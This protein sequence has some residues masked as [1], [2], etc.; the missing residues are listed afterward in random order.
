M[1]HANAEFKE[2]TMMDSCEM[3]MSFQGAGLVRERSGSRGCS[4]TLGEPMW[5]KERNA[6]YGTPYPGY[7]KVV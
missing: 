4:G 2:L 7:A 1:D 3:A 5:G 6:C